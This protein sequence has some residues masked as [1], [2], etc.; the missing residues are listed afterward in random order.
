MFNSFIISFESNQQ[1]S[2]EMI[3][4]KVQQLVNQIA[5]NG[6]DISQKVLYIQIR[7]IITYEEQPKLIHKDL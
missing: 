2:C 7:D 3:C 1:V 5:Q 6:D 4:S